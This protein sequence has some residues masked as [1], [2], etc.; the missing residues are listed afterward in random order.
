MSE[1]LTKAAV[2]ACITLNDVIDALLGDED[3]AG[4]DSMRDIRNEL[5]EAYAGLCDACSREHGVDAH[6]GIQMYV[7][8][9]LGA[10]RAILRARGVSL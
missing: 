8:V 1:N 4:H 3:I 7:G 5:S 9:E 6:A 2:Q 10:T